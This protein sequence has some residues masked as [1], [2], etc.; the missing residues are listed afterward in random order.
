TSRKPKAVARASPF[1]WGPCPNAV[2]TGQRPRRGPT[3]KR[4]IAAGIPLLVLTAALL[5]PGGAAT[6]APP[7]PADSTVTKAAGEACAFPIRVDTTGKTAF[8]DLPHNHH[9][10]AIQTA[11]GQRITV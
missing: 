4:S 1:D 3:M 11:P 2:S 5:T 10:T 8:I 9:F 6:G 7:G